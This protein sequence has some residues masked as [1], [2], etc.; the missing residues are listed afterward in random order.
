M[1]S[2]EHPSALRG[3]APERWNRLLEI[4]DERLQFGLLDR[5]KKVQAYHFEG[6]LLFIEACTPDEE[7]YLMRDSVQQQLALFAEEVGAKQ[8]TRVRQIHL[9]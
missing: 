4:L 8:G 6:E 9:K 3:N 1:S 5:L 7:R 2:Y